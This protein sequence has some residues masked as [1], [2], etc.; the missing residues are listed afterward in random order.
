MFH[1]IF[2]KSPYLNL[3]VIQ[4]NSV[5]IS[6][7]EAAVAQWLRYCAINRK[8]AG[9]IP[10]GVTGIFHWHKILSIALWPWGRLRLITLPP[11]RA[12]VMK[13]GNLNFLGPSGPLQACNGTALP[14]LKSPLL[15]KF[16]FV[17]THTDTPVV[18]FLQSFPLTFRMYYHLLNACYQRGTIKNTSW[19][20]WP[21]AS[22]DDT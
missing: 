3:S 18:R 7:R 5:H 12:A 22:Y 19:W 15:L 9:S 11:S 17:L 13:S 16:G 8:V 1:Y 14:Y 21:R 2:H 20:T 6:N 4:I 10:A